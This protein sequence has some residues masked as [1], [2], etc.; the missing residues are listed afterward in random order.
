MNTSRIFE[1][2]LIVEECKSQL[3]KNNVDNFLKGRLQRLDTEKRKN[4]PIIVAHIMMTTGRIHRNLPFCGERTA[5]G[6][7]LAADRQR[8]DCDMVSQKNVV[9][10]ARSKGVAVYLSYQFRSS[11]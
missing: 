4:F 3:S 7:A 10:Y 6:G 5:Q 2:L 11:N 8:E 9:E 1:E